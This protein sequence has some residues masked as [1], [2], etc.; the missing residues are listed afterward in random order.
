M[1][2][3]TKKKTSQLRADILIKYVFLRMFRNYNSEE[4]A[5]LIEI[6]KHIRTIQQ[7]LMQHYVKIHSQKKE[8][9]VNY[10]QIGNLSQ[11]KAPAR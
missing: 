3:N 11:K 5:C 9:P 7:L 4:P 10:D 1:R 8:S 2:E 6:T